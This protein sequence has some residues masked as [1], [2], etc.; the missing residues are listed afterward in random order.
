MYPQDEGRGKVGASGRE[1]KVEEGG[2]PRVDSGGAGGKLGRDTSTERR[3]GE[4]RGE[5]VGW[6]KFGEGRI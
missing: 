6:E 3:G 2:A 1:G 4:S 5:E